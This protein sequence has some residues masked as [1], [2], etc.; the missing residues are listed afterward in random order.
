MQGPPY[1]REGFHSIAPYLVCDGAARL[2]RFLEN[3][4]D[5][6]VRFQE[7]RPDGGVM[8]AE[9]EIGDSAIEL[10]DGNE[11]WK[12]RPCAVHIYVRDADSVYAKALAEGAAAVYEPVDREWGDRDGGVRDPC[13]NLWAIAT[14]RGESYLPHGRRTVTPYLHLAGAGDFLAFASK[15]FDAAEEYTGRGTDRSVLYARIRIGD[16]V[17]ETGDVPAGGPVLPGNLNVWVPDADAC[18]A[19]AIAAGAESLYAPTDKPYGD[20]ESGVRDPW[21]NSWFIATRIQK[22]KGPAGG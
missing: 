3:V 19:R 4:F 13:G 14:R 6:R 15:V 12:A 5:A 9:L 2:I 17:L 22:E 7:P 20:R 1:A 21:G 16:S 11:Q 18:Y 8:H 10:A